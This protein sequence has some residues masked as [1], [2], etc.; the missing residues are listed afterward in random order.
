VNVF[1]GRHVVM[2]AGTDAL[3]SRILQQLVL[4]GADVVLVGTGADATPSTSE[5]V[6]P[7][8]VRSVV[9][10]FGPADRKKLR[11]AFEGD[12]LLVLAG[13]VPATE[14]NPTARLVEEFVRNVEP[15]IRLV[16]AGG[17]SLAHVIFAS[18]AAVY[19]TA[20]RRPFL[21]SSPQSPATPPGVAMVASEHAVRLA[22]ALRGVPTAVMRHAALYGTG[23]SSDLVA[24][25]V[26]SAL[27]GSELGV[28]GNELDT[29]DYIHVDD[30]VEATVRAMALRADGAFNVGTGAALTIAHI[31][32]RVAAATGAAPRIRFADV[33][34]VFSSLSPEHTAEALGFRARRS[35]DAF[36]QLLVEQA[37]AERQHTVAFA[38]GTA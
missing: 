3:S 31:A 8:R 17:D 21:E 25:V 15:S 19:G 12:D 29:A 2:T 30:A 20:G 36:I 4:S 14:R 13:H 32:E 5:I 37:R 1:K 16:E 18:G 11:S 23:D 27:E 10:D 34:P 6:A 26:R 24:A 38:P 35:L 22:G 9:T 7:G 28:E 33:P